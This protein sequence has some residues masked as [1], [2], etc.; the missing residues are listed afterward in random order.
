MCSI[1]LFL[2]AGFSVPWGLPVTKDLL[3]PV[4]DAWEEIIEGFPTR[5]RKL[6][7]RVREAWIEHYSHCSGSVD[8]FAWMLQSGEPDY[9]SLRIE[10][11]A[12][13]LAIRLSVEQSSE[14]EFHRSRQ[15]TRHHITMQ[16]KIDPSYSVVIKELSGHQL[17]GIVTTN[18]D[19]VIE[20]IL[21]P[22]QRGRLGGFN[23]GDLEQPVIGSHQL[24]T[25]DWYKVGAITGAVPLLKLHGS[26]NWAYSDTQPVDVY[27][28]CK[29]SL[30][31]LCPLVVPPRVDSFDNYFLKQVRQRASEVI[32]RQLIKR[33][34]EEQIVADSVE[35]PIISG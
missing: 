18:Y 35:F 24:S 19:L 6:T 16:K 29:P 25:Q 7:E 22:H 32:I 34:S 11:L 23:Y 12:E 3:P 5:Q 13:F 17:T 2:G 28:D 21:G 14:R 1:A 31:R 8:G 26:L 15:F 30:R 27:V 33:P 20:K 10:D 9:P 4:R